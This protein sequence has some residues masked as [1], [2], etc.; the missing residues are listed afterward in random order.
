[1][2]A[3]FLFDGSQLMIDT[4]SANDVIQLDRVDIENPFFDFSF[5]RVEHGHQTEAN[6]VVVDGYRFYAFPS[7]TSIHFHG[8]AGNDRFINNT[9]IN[10]V[11]YGGAGT[12]TLWGGTGNDELYGELGNDVIFGWAGND[13]LVGAA[14][15]DRLFGGSGDDQL[16]SGP[17]IDIANGGTGIDELVGR[18]SGNAYL[19]N[20]TLYTISPG[21]FSTGSLEGIETVSLY[22]NANDNMIMVQGFKGNVNLHGNSGNDTLVGSSQDD[23]LYGGAGDDRIFGGLGDDQIVPGD[24]NDQIHGGGGHDLLVATVSGNIDLNDGELQIFDS[25]QRETD[26]FDQIE[27]VMITAMSDVGIRMDAADFSHGSVTLIGGSGNDELI[28]GSQ[29]DQLIGMGGN[30]LLIGNA[31]DDVLTGA[32]G[33]DRLLGGD[34]ADLLAGGSGNDGL[35][36]GL[37]IDRLSGGEGLDRYLWQS[38]DVSLGF[39]DAEDVRIVFTNT[40]SPTTIFYNGESI[41]Y[42]PANWSDNDVQLVDEALAV[43]QERTGNN[44]LLRT[45]RGSGITYERLGATTSSYVAW[46]RGATQQFADGTF[47]LGERWVHQVIFHEVGHNWERENPNWED[48]KAISGWTLEDMSDNP[49][50]QRGRV[51]NW[52]H[53]ADADFARFYGRSNPVEDFATSFAAYFTDSIGERSVRANPIPAKMAFIEDF[54]DDLAVV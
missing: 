30:D 7:V 12:D 52:Y 39:Q 8:N 49:D 28:G 38:E 47:N 3:D 20:N 26:T 44:V 36:G 1:M 5:L 24:G 53:L 43:L 51:G 17:G 25:D 48:F 40:T 15:N 34:G 6:G 42:G 45:A 54:I 41:E 2:A 13:L 10:S 37:G 23:Y 32:S 27:G 9:S 22:G 19:V 31:G 33:N 35:Y 18:V 29:G 50:Y 16:H 21:L 4:D 46:N 14:G 11:A